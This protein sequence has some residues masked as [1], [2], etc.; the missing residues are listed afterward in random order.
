MKMKPGETV[1]RYTIA[2]LCEE[3][4]GEDREDIKP[5]R[6]AVKR[7]EL[8]HPDLPW[9]ELVS[10]LKQVNRFIWDFEEPIHM[11]RLDEE[12]TMAGILSIRVR[13]LNRVRVGMSSLITKLC[14]ENG[15]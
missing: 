3:K 8:H 10:L 7:L 12:P 4:L 6:K 2:Q 5:L 9:A 13:K 14:K 1:D 15:R 11:G